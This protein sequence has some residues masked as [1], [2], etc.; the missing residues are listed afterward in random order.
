MK[1]AFNTRLNELIL[2]LE[3]NNFNL[4]KTQL[5]RY[6]LAFFIY[7][8]ISMQNEIRISQ[9]KY[10]ISKQQTVYACEQKCYFSSYENYQ[11]FIYALHGET[12][13]KYK[14]AYQ[15]HVIIKTLV[16]VKSWERRNDKN[17]RFACSRG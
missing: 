5:K 14:A 16:I 7:P 10:L 13:S 15:N 3:D 8:F 17:S 4:I 2:Y 9:T 6:N 12:T 1:L 11:P